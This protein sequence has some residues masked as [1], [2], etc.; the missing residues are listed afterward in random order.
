MVNVAFE[1]ILS[2][3]LKNQI[4]K[5]Q[6]PKWVLLLLK[7]MDVRPGIR[8]STY[9]QHKVPGLAIKGDGS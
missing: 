8:I 6:F 4:S 2:T 1:M 7:M 3:H 5:W 9:V